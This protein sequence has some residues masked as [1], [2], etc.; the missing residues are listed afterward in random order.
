MISIFI[1]FFFLALPGKE[2]TNL[3]GLLGRASL[4]LGVGHGGGLLS[5]LGRLSLRKRRS[6][7]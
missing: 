7:I 4:A 3:S 1:L 6:A 2:A 5:G